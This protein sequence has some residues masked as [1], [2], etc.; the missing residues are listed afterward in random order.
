MRSAI[1]TA[2]WALV[3]G[4]CING[5]G[6]GDGS[7]SGSDG[8]AT[9]SPGGG[10]GVASAGP[11]ALDQVPD[12]IA[13]AICEVGR[14][15]YLSDEPDCEESTAQ[16]YRA[17]ELASLQAAV[18]AGRV[19]YDAARAG[20]CLALILQSSGCELPECEGVVV[21]LVAEGGDCF[22][23][24]ECA[25][26]LFCADDAACPGA[27]RPVGATGDPCAQDDAC[28]PGAFCS[29][30]V[31]PSVCRP[32]A[33]Q[34]E[35]CGDPEYADC[36]DGLRCEDAADGRELCQPEP[37]LDAA[38]PGG[39]GQPCQRTLPPCASGLAC[40]IEGDAPVCR[41]RVPVGGACREGLLEPCVAGSYCRATGADEAI[42]TARSTPGQACEPDEEG[43]RA[44]VSTAWCG[45]EGECL[46]RGA[47]GGAC[48][49]DEGCY[50]D[51]CV[52]ARCAAPP[53]CED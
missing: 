37:A 12:R 3:L 24:E 6:S 52:D 29:F 49:Q 45:P 25:A 26:G 2:S 22:G 4:G 43:D 32:R 41:P 39:A 16:G 11:V 20:Q 15:C 14:R 17:T 47:N 30:A 18:A 35:S 13:A 36:A 31:E 21:G 50:S 28:A 23:R 27:C 9:P 44:C 1:W 48:A 51:N 40:V 7:G 38:T 33:G 42:C 19:R 53:V 34:G 46:A 5:G 10:P 8:G